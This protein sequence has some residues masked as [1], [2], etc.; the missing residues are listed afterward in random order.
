VREALASDGHAEIPVRGFLCFTKADL[1][2]LGARKIGGCE[3]AHRRAVA[4]RL[5]A[6]GPLDADQ[7]DALACSLD[8]S[9][10]PA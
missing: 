1:P 3:L 5:T 7:I 2:L 8:R 6:R 10:P 9:F 4:R